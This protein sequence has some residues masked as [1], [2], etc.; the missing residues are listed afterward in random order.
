MR[1]SI[2]KLSHNYASKNMI[3][4]KNKKQLAIQL[5]NHLSNYLIFKNNLIKS[6]Q[7]N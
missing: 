3:E 4:N 2:V 1:A 7:S 5:Q 6:K